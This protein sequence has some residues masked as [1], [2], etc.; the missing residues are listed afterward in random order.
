MNISAI[1]DFRNFVEKKVEPGARDLENLDEKNRV[2]VQKLVF[3]NLV[4]RFDTMS[5][6]LKIVEQKF[7]WI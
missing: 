2:H 4:D 6:F 3:T 5:L 1:N 7:Y